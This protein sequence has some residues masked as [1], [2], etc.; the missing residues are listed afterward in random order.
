MQ[1]LTQHLNSLVDDMHRT[2]DD[3]SP[4]NSEQHSDTQAD[5]KWRDGM[6][7][8]LGKRQVV[9]PHCTRASNLCGCA[10]V[11]SHTSVVLEIISKILY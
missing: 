4:S 7:R 6:L 9:F 1:R 3:Y 11:L 8:A 5:C 2:L 10:Q